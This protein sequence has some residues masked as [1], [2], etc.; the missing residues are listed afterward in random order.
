MIYAEREINDPS[1]DNGRRKINLQI[2][3]KINEWL[4]ASFKKIIILY[5]TILL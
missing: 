2:R 4:V 1:K 5:Y 3:K